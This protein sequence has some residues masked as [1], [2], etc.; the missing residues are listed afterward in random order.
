MTTFQ[1]PSDILFTTVYN[2]MEHVTQKSP[3]PMCGWVGRI[4][5]PD[6]CILG[7]SWSKVPLWSISFVAVPPWRP[8]LHCHSRWHGSLPQHGQWRWTSE[9]YYSPYH[10]RLGFVCRM[11]RNPL[12]YGAP[13]SSGQVISGSRAPS[14]C[15]QP[16]TRE[17]DVRRTSKRS[18]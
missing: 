5:H 1:C 6:S 3:G 8:F 10:W 9:L 14:R 11:W 2:A 16:T 7:S 15:K 17:Q 18:H 13:S 4:L 12:L